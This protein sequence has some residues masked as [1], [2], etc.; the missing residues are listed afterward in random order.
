MVFQFSSVCG[1]SHHPAGI[2]LFVLWIDVD[3]EISPSLWFQHTHK[4]P[5]Y[6]SM[7]SFCFD[8]VCACVVCFL[9][10]QCL[11][12]HLLKTDNCFSP[13]LCFWLVMVCLGAKSHLTLYNT[14]DCSLPGSSVHGISQERTLVWVPISFSRG[15]SRTRDWT[16]V[17]CLGGGFFTTEL[18]GKLPVFPEV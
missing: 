9:S 7:A 12:Y 3:R 18:P 14:V 11:F 1:V 17:S 8:G 2:A 6:T 16:R 15:S 5:S 4:S 13:I 10:A